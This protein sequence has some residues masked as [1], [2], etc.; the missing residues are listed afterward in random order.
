[1]KRF[2]TA[3]ISAVVIASSA[4]IGQAETYNQRTQPNSGEM[5]IGGLTMLAILGLI[6]DERNDRKDKKRSQATVIAP[7]PNPV[8]PVNPGQNFT[9]NHRPA[10]GIHILPASCA[11]QMPSRGRPRRV[12]T[13]NCLRESLPRR[14]ALPQQCATTA[15]LSLNRGGH[16]MTVY[17]ERCLRRF[18]FRNGR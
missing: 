5:I 14:V 16:P 7:P 4:N 8:P 10:Q 12:Y 3:A 11:L 18:G 17:R 1:M 13:E 15:H 2:V 6:I 9:N